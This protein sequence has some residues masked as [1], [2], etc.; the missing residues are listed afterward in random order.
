MVLTSSSSFSLAAIEFIKNSD[1]A[2]DPFCKALIVDL[3]E[4]IDVG[5]GK[6]GN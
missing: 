2:D 6:M 4:S 1:T 3:Q 5:D